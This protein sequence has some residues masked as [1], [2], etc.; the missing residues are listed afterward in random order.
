MKAERK[1]QFITY[2]HAKMYD[3]KLLLIEVKGSSED[4]F[5]GVPKLVP[6]SGSA[7]KSLYGLL[8]LDFINQP[9]GG[10]KR[11]KVDFELR[12]VLDIGKLPSELKG[13]KV[14]AANNADI[15]LL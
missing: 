2:L 7:G 1:I 8:E 11:V 12:T 9:V 3:Q 6:D 5:T 13:I 4:E 15:V 10:D 14:Q